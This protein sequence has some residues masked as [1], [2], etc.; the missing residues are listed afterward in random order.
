L[1]VVERIKPGQPETR[2]VSR[3]CSNR[4]AAGSVLPEGVAV[5]ALLTLLV[6]F[7]QDLN[8]VGAWDTVGGQSGPC[9]SSG[10][11]FSNLSL[12]NFNVD[13]ISSYQLNNNCHVADYWTSTGY[14]GTKRSGYRGNN[15]YVGASW[16]DNL[17]SMKVRS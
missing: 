2:V 1:T 4:H 11:G 6:T 13:G 3:T 8:Y 9:D 17:L 10:Y 14:T 7:F 12:V 16:N 15:R 5:P